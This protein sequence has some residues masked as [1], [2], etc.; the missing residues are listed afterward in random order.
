MWMSVLS[1]NLDI[2]MRKIDTERFSIRSG[3]ISS[4]L[5]VWNFIEKL[6]SSFIK[7]TQEYRDL[8]NFRVF[9]DKN[10]LARENN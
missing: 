3:A 5:Y 7:T 9:R 2:E 8:R 4:L 6:R 1:A 10:V